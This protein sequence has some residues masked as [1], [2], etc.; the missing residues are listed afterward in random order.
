VVAAAA[1]FVAGE[2]RFWAGSTLTVAEQM[3]R[4]ASGVM[5]G[6]RS[7]SDRMGLTQD[8]DRCRR[9]HPNGSVSPTVVRR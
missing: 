8:T 1:A 4:D 3:L 9:R 7:K 5:S 2:Q 6:T